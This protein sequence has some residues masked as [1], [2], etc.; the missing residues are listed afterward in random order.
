MQAALSLTFN[1]I[2]IQNHHQDHAEKKKKKKQKTMEISW[3]GN[4][5]GLASRYSY[6]TIVT[7]L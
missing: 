7:K 1:E 6:Y 5:K 2:K 4:V 3:Y